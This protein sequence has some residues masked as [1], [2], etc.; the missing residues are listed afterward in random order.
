MPRSM[1]AMSSEKK[2]AKKATVDLRVQSTKRKVKI[3]QPWSDRLVKKLKVG[4]MRC[5]E[6]PY[7]QVETE[8]IIE[9]IGACGHELR[10]NFE[11]TG[12]KDDAERDPETAV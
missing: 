8:F 7:Y 6:S 3:N 2:R 1:K 10:F 4:V 9:R 12:C 5:R 11:A